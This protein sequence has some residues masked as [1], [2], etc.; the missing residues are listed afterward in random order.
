MFIHVMLQCSTT[1]VQYTAW[2]I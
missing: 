1:F 2:P